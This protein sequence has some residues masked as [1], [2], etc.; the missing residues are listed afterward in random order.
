MSAVE[1]LNKTTLRSEAVSCNKNAEG[2]TFVDFIEVIV[3]RVGEFLFKYVGHL[4][5]LT[6]FAACI[7][8]S[9]CHFVNKCSISPKYQFCNSCKKIML[10]KNEYSE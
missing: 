5:T 8:L 3:Y 9:R 6:F 2:V 7:V 1:G 4:R 10:D